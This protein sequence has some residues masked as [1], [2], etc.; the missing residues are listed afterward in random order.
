MKKQI[1]SKK[2]DPKTQE[3]IERETTIESRKPGCKVPLVS[4]C[5]VPIIFLALTIL[6]VRECKRSGIRLEQEK[7]KLEQ[8]KDGTLVDTAPAIIPDTLKIGSFQK[9]YIPLLKMGKTR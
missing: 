5:L 8:M 4:G 2:I 7:I 3:L 9:A 1:K 6:S